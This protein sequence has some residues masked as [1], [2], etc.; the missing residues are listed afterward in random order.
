M[1]EDTFEDT[2][3]HAHKGSDWAHRN[4]I[5]ESLRSG[6]VRPQDLVLSGTVPLNLAS[7]LNALKYMETH[8]GT[9]DRGVHDNH[10]EE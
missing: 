8:Y 9:L 6:Q 10:E 1:D 3:Q 5:L 2:Y 4:Q 7:Q